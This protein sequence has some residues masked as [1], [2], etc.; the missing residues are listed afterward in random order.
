MLPV[1]IYAIAVY[2]LCSRLHLIGSDAAL[3]LAHSVLAIPFVFLSVSASLA[4]YDDTLDR[5]AASSGANAWRTFWLVRYPLIRPGMLAGA[6]FAF[7]TSFDEVVVALFVG[8]LDATL[9]MQ[10]FNEMRW[11]LSP[12]VAAIAA[13]LIALTSV[14]LWIAARSRR[15]D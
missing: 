14:A 6:L 1:I 7:I 4:R 12:V 10:M 3:I 8:G 11:N 15:S 13:M 5:A 2:A 9:P